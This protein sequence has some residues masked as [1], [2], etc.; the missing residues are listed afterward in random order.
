MDVIVTL[1]TERIVDIKK[2]YKLFEI[3]DRK[4]YIINIEEENIFIEQNINNA[5]YDIETILLNFLKNI[6]NNFFKNNFQ[7]IKIGIFYS[8]DK[9]AFLNIE[10][11]IHL[12]KLLNDYNLK[13]EISSYLTE[14]A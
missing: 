2:Y 10:F 4:G 9:I 12:I 5:Q 14:Q 6:D 1:I 3:L 13:L 7:T 8:L 11:S